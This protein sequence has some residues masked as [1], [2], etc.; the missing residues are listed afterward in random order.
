M[1]IHFRF[2]RHVILFNIFTE[3]TFLGNHTACSAAYD[4]DKYSDLKLVNSQVCEQ[5]NRSLRKFSE[6]LAH[7][8]F[9]N[10][11]KFLEV[12]F[13]Y[14]NMKSKQIIIQPF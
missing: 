7:M 1:R 12:W 4:I 8:T 3:L 6:R 11:L 13:A 10:Y 5:R 2:Y 9:N 14:V